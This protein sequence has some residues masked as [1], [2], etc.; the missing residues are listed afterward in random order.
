MRRFTLARYAPNERYLAVHRLAKSAPED[1]N[2]HRPEAVVCQAGKSIFHTMGRETVIR[3]C[4]LPICGT[5]LRLFVDRDPPRGIDR[6]DFWV[7]L[8]N[9]VILFFPL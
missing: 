9:R 7:V 2:E 4:S 3:G 6:N 5:D 8:N 1:H